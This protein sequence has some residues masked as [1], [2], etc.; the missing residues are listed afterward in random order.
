MGLVY[1]TS[2]W[3]A[4][5][6]VVVAES[7]ELAKGDVD[8]E[9]PRQQQERAR[10]DEEDGEAKRVIAKPKQSLRPEHRRTGNQDDA[11]D[12]ECPSEALAVTPRV[13]RRDQSFRVGSRTPRGLNWSFP[14]VDTVRPEI[15]HR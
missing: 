6:A 10:C 3:F 9:Y 2:I 12:E 5:R 14:H 11:E 7:R 8:D 4:D 15:E 1:E 13:I